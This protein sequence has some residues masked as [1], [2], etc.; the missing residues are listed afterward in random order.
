MA[1]PRTER[2][3]NLVIC[4]LAATRY[5]SKE[6]IRQAVPQ[7]ADCATDEAFERMFERDKD[8]L[9]EMG[10]PLET[11]SNEVLFDDEIGYRIPKDAYALPD[12]LVRLRRAGR[13]RGRRPHVAAR[14]A[15]RVRP[16]APSASSSPPGSTSTPRPWP[17]SSPGSMPPSRPSQHS[18]RPSSSAAGCASTTPAAGRQRRRGGWSPGGSSPGTVAGTSSVTT[19]TATDTR[20]FRLSRIHG[21]VAAEGRAGLVRGPGRRRHHGIGAHARPARARPATARLRVR[22]RAR[23]SAPASGRG[24]QRGRRV[25]PFSTSRSRTSSRWRR[26]SAGSVRPCGGGTGRPAGRRRAPACRARSSPC[27]AE[28][29]VRHH[30]RRG[31]GR[32]AD[33]PAG[34]DPV[35]AAASRGLGRRRRRRVRHLRA[36]AAGRPRA[37]LLLRPARAHARRP[38]RRLAWRTTGSSSPT[39]TPS[40]DRCASRPTRPSRC[41]PGCA[42][43][44]TSPRRPGRT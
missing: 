43:S 6:Q 35:A 12:G 33:P 8:D 14:H 22:S 20:V 7:Y 38:D 17:S 15:G 9:R 34:A 29:P 3:L 2:L 44:P 25:G 5:V 13:P 21:D 16:G 36:A 41:W 4:L 37:G 24:G 39:P 19:R 18:G 28:R 23:G 26:S 1:V 32:P 42:R 27:R 11:G 31:S 10:I 40:R 30:D